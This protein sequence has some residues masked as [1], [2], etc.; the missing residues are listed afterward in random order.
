MLGDVQQLRVFAA[1]F[2]TVVR[3]GKRI[4]K[5][6]GHVFVKLAVLLIGDIRFAA[7]P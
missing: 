6:M 4:I 1:T 3:P 5:V 2:N 7:C